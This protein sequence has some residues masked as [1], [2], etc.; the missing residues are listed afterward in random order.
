MM[1]DMEPNTHWQKDAIQL[2]VRRYQAC[3][4]ALGAGGS[5]LLE[6]VA[7]GE[8]SFNVGSQVCLF[9]LKLYALPIDIMQ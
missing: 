3:V 2:A 7:M 8:V 4:P 6:L 9:L 1:T 5:K